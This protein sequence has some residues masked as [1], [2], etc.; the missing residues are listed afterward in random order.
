MLFIL[1]AVLL[2]CHS[3]VQCASLSIISQLISCSVL[4]LFT[5]SN[6]VYVSTK[7]LA[8][9]ISFTFSNSVLGFSTLFCNAHV[10]YP[11]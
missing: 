11:F 1:L 10:I 5:H 8:V 3:A 9:H 2:Q 7:P 4:I 6:S